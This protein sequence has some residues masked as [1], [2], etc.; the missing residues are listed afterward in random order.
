MPSSTANQDRPTSSSSPAATARPTSGIA[1]NFDS[2]VFI[3]LGQPLPCVTEDGQPDPSG[4]CAGRE[5]AS[6]SNYTAVDFAVE[7]GAYLAG[8]LARPRP[9][10]QRPP[11]HH[12]W[13]PPTAASAT[14][15]SGASCNGA[16]SVDPDVDIEL[17][18][19]ADDE[20]AGFGD[21]VSARTFTEAFID[22]FQPDVL[23]PV[24]RG[25]DTA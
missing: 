5:F 7:D 22:V 17:A 6:P 3:D 11:R 16:R 13:R 9:D 21:P 23:L 8:L 20:E 1:R 19:L 12:Q 15:T 18:Y 10:A 25:D 24:G 2:T 14:A 4:T